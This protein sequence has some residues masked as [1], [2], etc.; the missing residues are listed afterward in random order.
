MK[1][2][3]LAAGCGTRMDSVTH[4][5]P[6]CLI[7]FGC[8]AILDRQIESLWSAGVSKIAIVVG[9]QA[10]RVVDHI[11]AS[12]A[13]AVDLFH[14][15]WNPDYAT[16][17]NISSLS[18]ARDWVGSH[19]FVCLN[20]DVLFHS[21]ILP[22]ALHLHTPASMIV[23]PE[24]RD[25]TMKVAIRH[26]LVVRMGKSIAR[27]DFS[28]AYIGIT[29]FSRLIVRPLF[30]EINF[31]LGAGRANEFYNVAVQNLA[32]RGVPVGFSGTF[33]L[34]WAEIEAPED[35]K[36]ARLRVLP[37]LHMDPIHRYQPLARAVA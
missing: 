13:D 24:W 28:G 15:I 19:S 6:K 21:A 30:D 1:A 16:T 31:L 29:A 35:L 32:D 10:H 18:L 9:H 14:V 7:R 33:W 25:E 12:Y 8:R 17:N 26:G 22:P 5:L 20:A 2:V 27:A 36:Y 4:G 23:D 3:I 37:R 34:P 11:R